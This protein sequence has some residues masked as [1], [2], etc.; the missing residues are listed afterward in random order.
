MKKLAVTAFVAALALSVGCAITNYPVIVDSGGPWGDQ[1]M[2]SYYDKAYIIPTSQVATFWADGSDELYTLVTQDWKGDQSLYTY[3]NFD[4]SLSVLF[5]DQRFGYCD[6]TRQTNCWIIRASNPDLPD[7]YPIGPTGQ[8]SG[9]PSQSDDPFDYEFDASCPGARSLSLLISDELRLG[10]C[11]SSLF[12]SQ[13]PQGFAREFAQLE[14]TTMFGSK[15]YA[16]PLNSSVAEIR[17]TGP[18]GEADVMPIYGSYRLYIDE[19]RRTI[20]QPQPSIRYQTRWLNNWLEANGSFV[21]IDVTYG[22]LEA[23]WRANVSTLGR[24]GDTY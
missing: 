18:S 16:L 3:N 23:T 15:V 21:D 12:A 8:G 17:L 2:D 5:L 11:G 9:D 13:D 24:Y 4:P 7:L 22:S 6:P 10:E 20:F 19:K 1:V 14:P